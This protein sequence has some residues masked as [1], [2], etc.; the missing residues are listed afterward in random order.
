MRISRH[1][2]SHHAPPN[3]GRLDGVALEDL[4]MA[5]AFFNKPNKEVDRDE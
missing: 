3:G 1:N 4:A 5:V 2:P